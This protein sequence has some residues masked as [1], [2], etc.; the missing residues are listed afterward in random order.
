MVVWKYDDPTHAIYKGVEWAVAVQNIEAL[1]ILLA[2]SYWIAAAL[3]G[4]GWVARWAV[5][6]L[7]RSAVGLGV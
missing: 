4:A 6:V 1:R 3:V 5:G 2:C 7:V